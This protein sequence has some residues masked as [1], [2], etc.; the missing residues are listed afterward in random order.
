MVGTSRY[1]SGYSRTAQRRGGGNYT[2][3]T[4]G[5][6]TDDGYNNYSTREQRRATIRREKHRDKAGKYSP[7]RPAIS[8]VECSSI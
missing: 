7:C 8:R 3:T 5:E 6:T 1:T 4:G 2:T